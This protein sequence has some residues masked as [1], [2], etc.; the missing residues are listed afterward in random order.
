MV[1]WKD[2]MEKDHLEKLGQDGR[3]ILRRVSKKWGGGHGVD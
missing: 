1:V 2:L 3:R